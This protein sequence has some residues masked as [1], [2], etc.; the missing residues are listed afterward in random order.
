MNA[1][2]E[3]VGLGLHQ[4]CTLTITSMAHYR[5]GRQDQL[6][7]KHDCVTSVDHKRSGQSGILPERSTGHTVCSRACFKDAA[8]KPLL[9]G[10]PS[11]PV[12]Q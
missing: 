5:P 3:I 11:R 8:A 1:L 4:P 9:S 6:D 10:S 7:Y 2:L 12:P